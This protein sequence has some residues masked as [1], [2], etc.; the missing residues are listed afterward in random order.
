VT[1]PVF[2]NTGAASQQANPATAL[3][4]GLPAS[5]VAG[6]FLLLIVEVRGL[7]ANC[8]TP[9]GWTQIAAAVEAINDYT[10]KVYGRFVPNPPGS[11]SVPSISWT[12]GGIDFAQSKIAQ[13]TNPAGHSAI[14]AMVE[15][16]SP[17]ANG[18]DVSLEL[19]RITAGGTD[20][21]AVQCTS[22]RGA[23]APHNAPT[24]PSNLYTLDHSSHY[25][26][27]TLTLG[28][29]SGS[30]AIITGETATIGAA[31]GWYAVGLALVGSSRRP[32]FFTFTGAP[33]LTEGQNEDVA[34]SLQSGAL[35]KKISGAWVLQGEIWSQPK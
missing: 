20:R 22:V 30:G 3:T 9:N 10:F 7:A 4:P 31:N 19:P 35:Y 6:N 16:V 11:L 28:F 21:R 32:A 1:A 13:Y 33:P 29:W 18:V 25:S 34:F 23:G 24:I 5:L 17:V 14:S 15:L 2:V 26:A 8:A 27:A 12:G